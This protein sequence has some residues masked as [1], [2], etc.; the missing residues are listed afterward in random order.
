LH[1]FYK[2]I[3]KISLAK[4][5]VDMGVFNDIFKRFFGGFS[6][7]VKQQ[8]THSQSEATRGEDL[9][10]DLKL[11]F[12]EAIFGCEKQI[13]IVHL[14]TCSICSGTGQI[15]EHKC[16]NCNGLGLN[17]VAKKMKITIPAGV[18][19]GIRL[20][21]ANEGNAGLRGSPSGDLYIYLFVQPEQ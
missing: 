12:R 18:D 14:E 16:E 10:I 9:R 1:G 3:T 4:E 20:R 17:N 19:S 6:R 21:V 2:A 7:I 13:E 5:E 15:N 11:E 8:Q